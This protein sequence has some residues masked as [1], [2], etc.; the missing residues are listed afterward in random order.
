MS[1]INKGRLTTGFNFGPA[2]EDESFVY[3][4]EEPGY[5]TNAWIAFMRDQGIERVCCLQKER[6]PDLIRIYTKEFGEDNVKEASIVDYH[7]A[8]LTT[9]KHKI[10]PFLQDSYEKKK[11]VV[12]HC[13]GGRGRTGHVLAAWLVFHYGIKPSD[14]IS[15]VERMGRKPKEAVYSGNASMDELLELLLKCGEV[16]AH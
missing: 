8:T 6:I 15:T 7:L 4:A 3:G 9:L 10:L 5:N 12:V 13:A 14:A 2:S 11:R 1:L 16:S